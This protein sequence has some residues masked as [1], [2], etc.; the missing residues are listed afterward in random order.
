MRVSFTSSTAAAIGAECAPTILRVRREK[1]SQV[2][3]SS[4][5]I[6]A[7]QR[8]GLT[9]QWEPLQA[10]RDRLKATLKDLGLEKSDTAEDN[11]TDEAR[12]RAHENVSTHRDR[13]MF[14]ETLKH[15]LE[16]KIESL[17]KTAGPI[18]ETNMKWLN[19]ASEGNTPLRQAVARLNQTPFGIA[20][21]VYAGILKNAGTF[22]PA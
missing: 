6:A 2:A 11:V 10:E 17:Q 22:F 12:Q 1:Q 13:D 7:A 20:P 4:R 8:G 21:V 14:V 15:N 18:S 16:N 19:A 5:G 9:E 3:M